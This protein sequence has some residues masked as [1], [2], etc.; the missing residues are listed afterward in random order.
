MS[1]HM[2]L[3]STADTHLLMRLCLSAAPSLL[4]GGLKLGLGAATL[5]CLFLRFL[6]A[7]ARNYLEVLRSLSYLST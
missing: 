1:D 5:S 6:E 4:G 3:R 2:H 7:Q